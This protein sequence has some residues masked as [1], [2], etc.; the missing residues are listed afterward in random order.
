M[1]RGQFRFP[2]KV[3]VRRAEMDIAKA[4]VNGLAAESK[5]ARSLATSL[6][7]GIV[8]KRHKLSECSSRCWRP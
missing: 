2:K 6:R 4:L 3:E 8:E 7:T 5:A 1:S